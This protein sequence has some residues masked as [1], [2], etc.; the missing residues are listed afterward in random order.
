[1]DKDGNVTIRGGG[2]NGRS[3]NGA[4]EES[5]FISE[6]AGRGFKYVRHV[7]GLTGNLV[8]REDDPQIEKLDI[9][10]GAIPSSDADGVYVT[11]TT[12]RFE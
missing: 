5:A 2:G 1:M 7:D 4:I 12:R 8:R 6:M 10:Y 11:R 3:G 9:C